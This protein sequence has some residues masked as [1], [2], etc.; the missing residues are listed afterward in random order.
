MPTPTVSIAIATYRSELGFLREAL[1]SALAQDFQDLEVIVTDDSSS[2]HIQ[3]LV[4]SFGDP[5]IRYRSNSRALGVAQNH[6]MAFHEARAPFLAILNHDD[7]WSSRFLSTL[8]PPLLG[9]PSL[10]ASFCDHHLMNASGQEL[11][12]ETDVA[13]KM[14]GR[15]SLTPG[16][17]TS[18]VPFVASQTIPMA[19]GCVFRK[20]AL[21]PGEPRHESGP[22][23]DL[24]MTYLLAKSGLGIYYSAERLSSWRSHASNITTKGSLSWSMGVSFCW[25][26]ISND[27]MFREFR[28]VARRKAALSLRA[29]AVHSLR[30]GRGWQAYKLAT[31]S[32]QLR[33]L[34]MAT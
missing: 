27:E 29:A 10:A 21:P 22:A 3:R 23:Y 20:S 8:V 34:A 16:V 33:R 26:A 31:R 6:A 15:A 24:W 13:S 4:Y 17:Y 1:S 9:D 7:R 28:G 18:M 14:W 19:M 12:E 5:R 30:A 2:E 11:K 32:R 25:L